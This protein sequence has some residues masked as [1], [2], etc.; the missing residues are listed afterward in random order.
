V[1]N[2]RADWRARLALPTAL[3]VLDF[4]WLYPWSVL[5]AHWTGAPAG[6]ALLSVATSLTLLLAALGITRFLPWDSWSL[7]AR[8]PVV[9][10]VGIALVTMAVRARYYA[11]D[12]F[13]LDWS[14]A[15]SD[16]L[17]EALSGPALP[18]LAAAF[19]FCLWWR[20]IVRGRDVAR[21]ERVESAFGFGIL[22]IIS[23]LVFSRANGPVA[24]AALQ[25]LVAIC[26]IGFFLVGL[27]ALAIARIETE[28]ADIRAR[29]G[30]APAPNRHW[31]FVLLGTTVLLLAMSL[32]IGQLFLIDLIG[33]VLGPILRAVGYVVGFVLYLFALPVGFVLEMIVRL[34]RQLMGTRPPTA[35]EGGRP[36]AP[37][38]PE[39]AVSGDALVVA[40][41]LLF[42]LVAI[43]LVFWLARM[44][45]KPPVAET[46]A[47]IADEHESVLAWSSL[48]AELASWLEALRTWLF[49]RRSVVVQAEVI[50]LPSTD[51]PASARSIREVYRQ[52]LALARAKGVGHGPHQT[53]YERLPGLRERLRPDSN[54]AEITEVYVRARYGPDIPTETE[55]AEALAHLERVR[56]ES[57][58]LRQSET[59]SPPSIGPPT[60]PGGNI[61]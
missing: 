57:T 8:R 58:D 17:P 48:R 32:L 5:V 2:V 23:L 30:R 44:V 6:T 39:V 52:L 36:E 41:W 25:S 53:P 33:A 47:D 9:V 27:S 55:V 28:R 37:E 49:G 31:F 50:P 34:I 10:V 14:G 3:A 46:A 38:M 60:I 24:Y 61:R 40:Q 43:G 12:L 45:K 35:D 19:G 18:L 15:R 13:S 59:V 51:Q 7:A 4:F 56:A 54:L 1:A 29:G 16:A 26:L 21:F 22:A 11:A 42:A 20:G